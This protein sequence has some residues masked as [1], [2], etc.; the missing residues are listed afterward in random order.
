M[1]CGVRKGEALKTFNELQAIVHETA[2]SKGWHDNTERGDDGFPTAR[3]IC[4]YLWLIQSELCESALETEN[5]YTGENGKPEGIIIEYADAVIRILDTAGAIGVNAGELL[6]KMFKDASLVGN[7][8]VDA[9][10]V[11]LTEDV[12][13][14][15]RENLAQL[16]AEYAWHLITIA[17]G[18]E[19]IPQHID[20]ESLDKEFL[21]FC[22]IK[23]QFNKLRPTRHGGKLA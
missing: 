4:C 22:V 17:D 14:G 15:K 18:C 16:L 23:A 21:S 8:T 3:Q 5:F 2:C 20:S 13:L 12:R 7:Y 6:D 1:D 10:L 9:C 19:Y 11:R